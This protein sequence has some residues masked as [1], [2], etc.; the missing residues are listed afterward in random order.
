MKNILIIGAGLS[1][2]TLIEYLLNNAKEYDWQ[3]T[4]GDISEE[5]ARAKV[6]GHPNGTAKI[7]D[8][9]D[10]LQSWRTIADHDVVISMLPAHM[11]HQVADKCLDLRKPMLTASYATP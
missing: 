11:H 3:I 1:T 5:K 10:P 8:I 9:K 4:V 2:T 7:F 6:N